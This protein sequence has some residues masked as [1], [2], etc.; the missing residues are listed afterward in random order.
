MYTWHP[1]NTEPHKPFLAR[2]K[3]ATFT[4]NGDGNGN[5]NGS[6]TKEWSESQGEKKQHDFE[7]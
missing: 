2:V 5:G 4:Q 1:H 7:I 3:I 6:G